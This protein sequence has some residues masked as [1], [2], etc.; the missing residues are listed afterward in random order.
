MS[1]LKDFCEIIT[2]GTTPSTYGYS[3]KNSGIKFIR[4][5][6]IT[7]SRIISKVSL[8]ISKEANEKLKRSILLKDDVLM[9]IA[10][11]YLGK[12]A[13][14]TEMDLP[15]NTNQA[16]A[17][18]RTDKSK[19]S[20]LYLYYYLSSYKMQCYINNVNAQSAQ[21]NINLQ[22]IGDININ[23]PNLNYQ[24][25][26]VDIIGSLDDK[27]EN[28]NKIIEK[29][30]RKIDFIFN[31]FYNNM[32]ESNIFIKYKLKEYAKKIITG[33]TPST[34]EDK[35]WGNSIDFI[36]IPDM[37]D[38]VYILD[39][40]RKLSTECEKNFNNRIVPKNS[41]AI[42]CIATVG[43]VS[44]IPHN[45]ITNQQINSV[46]FNDE[47]DCYYFYELFKTMKENLIKLGSGGSATLNINKN[48]F[49]NIEVIVPYKNEMEQFCKKTSSLF[50]LILSLT[51]EN[52]KL[53]DLKQ[54]Y[55]KKF[56]G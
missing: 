23:V 54:L 11:A 24:Q 17:I 32:L 14:I 20:P 47:N 38:N 30:Q 51:K 26:I 6:N 18:I 16:V 27:I 12:L 10:G 3:F 13:L 19:L 36:T 39:T 31:Q 8:Y 29:L 1:Y 9:S 48:I 43:L 34:K 21:P 40:I 25:H 52:T 45:A 2:K 56:F 41:I 49:S 53:N 15:A 50:E 46:I 37:R 28:N 42:S 35:Y 55:L 33:T 4:S 7:D 44:I 5:E 22:Q